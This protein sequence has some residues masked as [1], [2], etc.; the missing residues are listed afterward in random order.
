M[1][2]VDGFH[3]A[4]PE[5]DFEAYLYNSYAKSTGQKGRNQEGGQQLNFTSSN[6]VLQLFFPS[7]I[8]TQDQQDQL[9]LEDNVNEEGK[10]DFA[11]VAN[12]R[13]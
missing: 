1:R 5:G 7:E 10:Q 6:D 4:H 13:Q 9:H 11:P 3:S 12:K 8:N 2:E